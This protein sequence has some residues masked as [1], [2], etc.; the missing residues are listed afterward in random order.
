MADESIL[1][2]GYQEKEPE[3]FIV[4][5]SSNF[6][7]KSNYLSEF[8]SE[9]EQAIVRENLNVPSKDN[10]YDKQSVD[11]LIYQNIRDGIGQHLNTED[12]HGILSQVETLIEAM[13]KVD[14]TTPFVVPQEG[15]DP[16][17]DDHL[18]TKRFVTK[19]L[20]EHT[21]ADDPH[22][23]LPEVKD[24][25]QQYVKLSQI[26]TKNQVYTKTE[27]DQKTGQLVKKDGTTPFTKPQIGIDPTTDSHLATKRYA[28]KVLYNHL[29]DVDPHGF[30]TIL[31]NRLAPFAKKKDVYDKTQ[32]Y[33][34]TQIDS[35]I[36]S[37]VNQAI[38]SSI[39]DY[40]DNLNDKIEQI[41]K[42]KYVKSD[43]SIAFINPQKGVDAVDDN[44]LVTLN[45]L[46]SVKESLEGNL[47]WTTSG[48]VEVTVG[49]VQENTEVP[50]EMTF[51]EIMDAIFY[52]KSASLEVPEYTTINTSFPITMCIHGSTSFIDYVD[53]YQNGNPL[54]T[55]ISKESFDEG[56][57][58]VDS[59]ADAGDSVIT[60]T[61]Y[62][63]NGTKYEET[64]TVKCLMPVFVGLLPKW[65]FANTIT[66]DY[67]EELSK[68]NDNNQFLAESPDLTSINF[69]YNFQDPQLLH[70]FIVIPASYPE[71]ESMITK[72]QNFGI[73]AFDVI[74][75]IPL[76]VQ[77]VKNDIIY[78]VYVYR[79][80]LSSLNQEVTF[81]FKSKE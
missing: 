25:L 51:Q 57:V 29:V 70:P 22:Q 9:D 36:L 14:G 2:P 21:N 38:S 33:S 81:N 55:G 34:R 67:L 52:G 30:I 58:T 42:Q 73:D 15:V 28:D 32:T 45:Q 75:M 6:L 8:S 20:K 40:V 10:I 5:D 78:K 77:G 43:A 1:T 60:F 76:T 72:S 37:M 62:Y 11:A 64:A 23:I 79:Q 27:V 24:L 39:Q 53:L 50:A 65:K 12:P 80:A 44:D 68:T 41:R 17:S 3:E 26:Y 74:D 46:N 47:T 54:Y 13:V 63:T 18:T 61:V 7:Q 16:I 69:K 35:L 56:C 71:L 59:G 66:M 48:P 19:L 49:K 31:N 4:A